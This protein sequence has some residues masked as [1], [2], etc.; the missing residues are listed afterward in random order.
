M[1]SDPASYLVAHRGDQ[2][3][4][5]ENTL[6]AFEAAAKAGARY[7]ECDIQFTRD[8]VPVVCHDN[9]IDSEKISELVLTDLPGYIPTFEALLAWLSKAPHITLF[10]EIKP[11][12]LKRRS[13][14]AA[15]K[16]LHAMIPG[17]LQQ[18]IIPISMSARLVEA[19]SLSF[20]TPVGWVM[21]G[22]R[23]PN[24]TLGWL[25]F[26]WQQL[27][28]I[29]NWP[30]RKVRTAAYTV[31]DALQAAALHANGVDLIETNHFSRLIA[32]LSYSAASTNKK[33]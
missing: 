30:D 6:A 27:Q 15:A 20:H 24:V 17:S 2:E 1:T 16:F 12:I 23:T 13:A 8:M 19:C 10:L 32:E 11:P 29:R 9:R 21:E 33:P 26:P 3:S 4:A 31:N 7:I 25:F 22:G 5:C 28:Q 14:G 18:Q